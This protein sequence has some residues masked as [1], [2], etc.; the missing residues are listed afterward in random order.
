MRVSLC[1]AVATLFAVPDDV[2]A[3][4]LVSPEITPH[5]LDP[6]YAH[7]T[8]APGIPRATFSISRHEVGGGCLQ[9]DCDG[10]YA[11]VFVDVTGDDDQTPPQRLGYILTIAGGDTPA[12]MYTA[13]SNGMPVSQPQGSFN[14][15]FDYD[16]HEYAFDLAIRTVDLNGNVSEPT[17]LHIAEHEARGCS[18]TSSV[19]SDWLFV[20]VIG[21]MLRRRRRLA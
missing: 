18:T 9:T 20:P 7:D 6:A 17:V 10:K 4:V 19:R 13:V 16:D 3:C 1:A 11:N 2:D 5:E 12:N 15:G 14:F 8:V 21:F